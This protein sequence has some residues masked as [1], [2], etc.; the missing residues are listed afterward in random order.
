MGKFPSGSRTSR[1][2]QVA[3]PTSNESSGEYGMRVWQEGQSRADRLIDNFEDVKVALMYV[4][5]CAKYVSNPSMQSELVSQTGGMAIDG[6]ASTWEWQKWN[7]L[8]HTL[9]RYKIQ[10][11]ADLQAEASR[12]FTDVA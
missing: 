9:L 4:L 5:N 2:I 10:Q 1:Q 6:G 8:I 11:G 12:E 7:G 3:Q